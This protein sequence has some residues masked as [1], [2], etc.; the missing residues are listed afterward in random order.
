MFIVLNYMLGIQ[1]LIPINH[2]KISIILIGIMI[3]LNLVRTAQ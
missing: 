2:Y 1:K 3:I